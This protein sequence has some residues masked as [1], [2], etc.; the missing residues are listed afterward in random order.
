MAN[1]TARE[2]LMLELI[3]RARMDPRGEAERLDVTLSA[4]Q[5]KPVQ[6]TF[7]S[8]TKTY[9][10]ISGVRMLGNKFTTVTVPLLPGNYEV[11]GR[12]KGYEEVRESL[13]I[14]ADDAVNPVTIIANKKI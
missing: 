12:R 11:I 9:V 8:D 14:R 7:I 4:G 2:Q 6:V 1:M 3:N 13:R 5:S 10:T